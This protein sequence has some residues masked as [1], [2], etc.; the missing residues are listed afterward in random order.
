MTANPGGAYVIGPAAGRVLL[1]ASGFLNGLKT[2]RNQADTTFGGLR[3][4]AGGVKKIGD[5][6]T[7][8]GAQTSLAFAPVT[9]FVTKGL[10]AFASYDDAMTEIKA[11][12]GATADEMKTMG[13][14]A[15]EMGRKTQFS[16]TQAADGLLQ[17]LTSGSS[18]KEAMATLP[19]VLDLAAASSIDLGYAAD[20]VTDILAQF[21]LG[22]DKS[23]YVVNALSQA[24]QASSATAP[25]MIDALANVGPIAQRFGLSVQDT[26]AILANFAENGIKGAEA[27]TQLKSM[28]LNM[29]RSS[30][31]VQKMWNGIGVSMYDAHGN[32]RDLNA[33]IQD[34]NRVMKSK[35]PREQNEIIQTLAGTYGQ[36]GMSILLATN[37]FSAMEQKMIQQ[38]NAADVAKGKMSSFRNVVNQLRSSV[39]TFSINVLGPL[40]EKRI[41]PTIKYVTGLVNKLIEWTTVNPQ[42]ASQLGDLLGIMAVIGPIMLTSGKYISLLGS[43]LGALLSP[44][45][46]LTLAIG[47]F[48]LAWQNNWLGI[49]EITASIVKVLTSGFQ[50]VLG[51]LD[52]ATYALGGTSS[53]IRY[54]G[55]LIGQL[56]N[57]LKSGD[58]QKALRVFKVMENAIRVIVHDTLPLLKTLGLSLVTW[59][60]DA[61][62]PTVKALEEYFKKVGN[63]LIEAAPK[64]FDVAK[65]IGL[66]I[67]DGIFS[68]LGYAGNWAL[69]NVLAP[70]ISNLNNFVS[71]NG[72]LWNTAK[73]IG[74]SILDG[75]L[76]GLSD[77]AGWVND[78][79]L[80][81]IG[82][83]LDGTAVGNAIGGAGNLLSKIW[84]TLSTGTVD[85]VKWVKEH[86]WNPIRDGIGNLNIDL[87][88]AGDFLQGIF[89]TIARCVVDVAGWVNEKILTPI[90][91]ALADVDWNEIGCFINDMFDAIG[92]AAADAAGWIKDHIVKPIG[93]ALKNADWSELGNTLIDIFE[94]IGNGIV[95]GAKWAY[96][97]I[98]K[99]IG[100]WAKN[101]D[102]S[103]VGDDL[104]GFAE[105]LWD[106]LTGAYDWAGKAL[107][108]TNDNILSPIGDAIGGGLD[109]IGSTTGLWGSD[110]KK[111]KPSTAQQVSELRRLKDWFDQNADTITTKL[112]EMK[113]AAN[114]FIERA[115][116][117][118]DATQGAWNNI[119]TRVPDI[120]T[121][122][123][124]SI[125]T[126]IHALDEFY[127]ALV[128]LHY[129]TSNEAFKAGQDVVY[130]L[131]NGMHSVSGAVMATAQGIAGSVSSAL[132]MA[133]N[134][135]HQLQSVASQ[136]NSFAHA[137]ASQPIS[138]GFGS[139]VASHSV[140]SGGI[141]S[142]VNNIQVTM[143][144]VQSS[145]PIYLGGLTAQQIA[146]KLRTQGIY[147]G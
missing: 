29:T 59:A 133:M 107:S 145:D 134:N 81:P 47:A 135:L 24:T 65:K 28:L 33:V 62:D 138:S 7:R 110:K 37:G 36:A 53:A 103:Q 91:E 82:Q 100:E 17:L 141:G 51:F 79:I 16:S 10:L 14:F 106:G 98:A 12:T 15:L 54:F 19:S 69:D 108:W 52:E 25:M 45:G 140:T 75:A 67:I 142:V 127:H 58:S 72:G 43:L 22:V 124:K 40:V 21:Q 97:H 4:M 64:I 35:T 118:W 9:A 131:Q 56:W 101:I 80:V 73:N 61:L 137:A 38:A 115:N 6:L 46:L 105:G 49:R 31:D 121:T 93:E 74:Q 99:P 139:A 66:S 84:D 68:V 85:V 34:L 120:M 130:G 113:D 41:K 117:V 136:A 132:S 144:P 86:I 23:T 125:E 39:E 5:N 116:R 18:V 11:R 13:D 70:L 114:L 50:K 20:A 57:A 32:V 76:S 92:S 88:P 119:S 111:E 89:N 27:G 122:I 123:R 128:R 26:S 3:Q 109:W 30:E 90:G 48:Y 77:I 55:F 96:D 78:H 1:D 71:R 102:W 87:G 112:T 42:I 146:Q 143:P 95:D 60:V 94:A 63:L 147:G 129:T 104:V 8:M 126:S 2:V 83:A 44:V